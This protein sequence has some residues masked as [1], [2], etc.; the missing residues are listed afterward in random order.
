MEKEKNL[1]GNIIYTLNNNINGSG[2][3]YSNDKYIFEGE[4]LNGQR[5]G[6][7]KEYNNKGKLIFEGEYFNDLKW[8]GKGF[9]TLNNIIYELRDGKGLVKEYKDY[10]YGQ[11][12]Y[13]CEYLNGKRNGKGKEYWNG[14]LWFEGEYLNGQRHGKGKEYYKENGKFFEGEYLY[15]KKVKGKFYVNNKLEYEG[16]YLYHKKWNGKGYDENGNI[17][18]EVIKGNGK[19]REYNINGEFE[20]EGEYLNGKRHGKGKEYQHAVFEGEEGEYEDI[21]LA[22]E[23]EYLNGKRNGKGKKYDKHGNLFFE[24]EFVNGEEIE[25]INKIK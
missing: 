24:G 14:K 11:L 18:Y 8:N 7:G 19:V 13:E 10:F 16:E 5:N 6:K 23:G 25:Y 12:M 22:F 15:D 9:D 20:F 3:E 21:Y 2:K 1:N 17:I 4:Y